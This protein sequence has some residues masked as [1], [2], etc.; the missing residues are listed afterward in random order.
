MVQ[1]G[2]GHVVASYNGGGHARRMSKFQYKFSTLCGC[3]YRKGNLLFSRDG[4]SVYSPV[5]NRITQFDLR[6]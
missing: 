4:D 2:P 6:K 3:V 5:G 1:L